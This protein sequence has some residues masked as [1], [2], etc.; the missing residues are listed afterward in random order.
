MIVRILHGK[1]LFPWLVYPVY[2]FI[3]DSFIAPHMAFDRKPS[4]VSNNQC[5]SCVSNLLTLVEWKW[6][7]LVIRRFNYSA[8]TVLEFRDS[9]KKTSVCSRCKQ[10]LLYIE[11]CNWIEQWNNVITGFQFRPMHWLTDIN[12]HWIVMRVNMSQTLWQEVCTLMYKY[13]SNV[14]LKSLC[15]IWCLFHHLCC[16]FSLSFRCQCC[17]RALCSRI[18][19]HTSHLKG[20][21]FRTRPETGYSGSIFITSVS[22][23]TPGGWTEGFVRDLDLQ[24]H[25]VSTIVV[26]A[27]RWCILKHDKAVFFHILSHLYSE[28][29]ISSTLHNNST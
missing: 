5:L 7:Y 14:F 4:V 21:V 13:N 1:P 8:F 12:L 16:L 3:N 22:C 23:S 26:S 11:K 28:I 29:T 24:R 9:N 20:L 17:D 2:R 18:I 25:R 27:K 6:C 10:C 19:A 15:L